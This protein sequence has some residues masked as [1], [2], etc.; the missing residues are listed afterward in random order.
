[1]KDTTY[2][3][4]ALVLLGLISLLYFLDLM[5]FLM[6]LIPNWYFAPDVPELADAYHSSVNKETM[7]YV[8][9]S[10]P[11]FVIF[12][13]SFVLF[14]LRNKHG[15]YLA[16]LGGVIYLVQVILA[17]IQAMDLGF[18]DLS[19]LLG[20]FLVVGAV[21]LLFCVWKSKSVFE[22]VKLWSKS[23]NVPSVE[24]KKKTSRKT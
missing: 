8:M 19:L 13:A 14:F 23:S 24:A 11:M 12:S 3:I 15:F 16:A 20:A 1:M 17:V 22:E 5:I 21:A 4:I 9:Q 2:W 7:N 6:T 10:F 18:G